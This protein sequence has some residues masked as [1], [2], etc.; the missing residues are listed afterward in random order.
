M[1]SIQFPISLLFKVTTFSNDFIAK[2]SNGTTIAYVREKMLKL[3]DTIDIYS[4]ES[5]SRKMYQIRADRWLDFN[6]NYAFIDSENNFLGSL[7]RKG[8]ASLWSSR[9]ESY[10]RNRNLAYVISEENPFVK[11][12]DGIFV[13]IPIVGMLTGY[14]FNP[15]YLVTSNQTIV[16][17]LIKQPSLFGRKFLIEAYTSLSEDDTQLVFLSL[18]QM[19]LLERERG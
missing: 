9:Y 16:A 4:D 3:T 5:K 1:H 18:A 13:Q 14:F 19:V 2:D 10:D 11:V 7:A 12:I 17:K 8:W 15:S 6:A